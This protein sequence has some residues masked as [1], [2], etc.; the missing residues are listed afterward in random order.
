MHQRLAFW[1]RPTYRPKAAYGKGSKVTE[2]D[3]G[4]FWLSIVW[5]WRTEGP[6][7]ATRQQS[8]GHLSRDEEESRFQLRL[9]AETKLSPSLLLDLQR[10][11]AR[12]AFHFGVIILV[13]TRL[14][15]AGANRVLRT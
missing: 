1:L 4:W 5:Y 8:G 9:C 3:V 6:P 14:E 11:G 7:E 13:H 10:D 15:G 12:D 2:C